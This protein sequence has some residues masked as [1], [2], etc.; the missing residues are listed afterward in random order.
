MWFLQETKKV[1][2]V[3]MKWVFISE[4]KQQKSCCCRDHSGV[5]TVSF[6]KRH[7]C[8]HKHPL[9]QIQVVVTGNY[10]NMAVMLSAICLWIIYLF[11]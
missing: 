8:N 11:L 5:N 3:V 7:K 10:L 4:L 1:L 9:I 6:I 2:A